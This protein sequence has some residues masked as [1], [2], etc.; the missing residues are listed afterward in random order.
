[1]TSEAG[2]AISAY[3]WTFDDGAEVA[4]G[5]KALHAFSSLGTHR[6][7]LTVTDLAGLSA[8]AAVDVSV[9]PLSIC[10]E[11][12]CEGCGSGEPL[13]CSLTRRVA[14]LR[15]RPAAFR[16][17][18]RGGPTGGRQGGEVS[19]RVLGGVS[20]VEFSVRRMLRA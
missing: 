1:M 14:A 6:A 15:I 20:L 11:A 18:R 8:S 5:A 3:R 17:A 16:A 9:E 19:Y 10:A 2:D 12:A 4:P 13:D 7:T